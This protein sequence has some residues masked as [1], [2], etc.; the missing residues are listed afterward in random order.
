MQVVNLPTKT[1]NKVHIFQQYRDCG[2]NHYTTISADKSENRLK[3][4]KDMFPHHTWVIR[5]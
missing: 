3:E 4:L 5:K 1:E 2:F